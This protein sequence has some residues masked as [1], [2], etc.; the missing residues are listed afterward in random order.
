MARKA[1]LM[2][3]PH[4]AREAHRER[5]S[6][7][8]PGFEVV[9]A[10]GEAHAVTEAKE[11]EIILGHRYLRQCLPEAKSLNWVQTTSNGVDHL[12][13]RELEA[14][15]VH[16]TRCVVASKTLARHAYAMA[17]ALLRNLAVEVPEGPSTDQLR[18]L[19]F[20][21]TAVILGMGPLGKELAMLLRRDGI[22]VIGVKQSWDSE[23]DQL[24]DHL[25]T[26]GSFVEYLGSAD[27]CF[28]LLPLTKL[29]K[30]ILNQATLA[31]LP[32]DAIF[33]NIGRAA[34]VDEAA[35][36]RLLEAGNL[37][38]VGLDV[39]SLDSPFRKNQTAPRLNFI[40]TP[41]IGAHYAERQDEIESFVEAQV[42]DYLEGR[43]LQN[44][45]NLR[46]AINSLAG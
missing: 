9:I 27:L 29:T 45:V 7:I 17:W 3:S 6:R 12:P 11:A 18:W 20:P 2:Y 42:A 5:L 15:G 41:Y 25:V 24:C 8:A 10:R 22:R 34:T 16:L 21:K 31:K 26:S 35:L 44:Q 36:Y 38:G 37:G 23:S 4:P 28:C 1:V 32:Q 13:L 46:D 30:G 39:S 43:S 19:P 40:H 14:K 33:I